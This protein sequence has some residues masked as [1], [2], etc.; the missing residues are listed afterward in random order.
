M[1]V[2][3]GVDHENHVHG[4]DGEVVCE[5]FDQTREFLRVETRG[6]DENK[7]DGDEE[8]GS[9]MADPVLGHRHQSPHED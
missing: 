3:H 2:A 8:D 5:S 6:Q 9:W 1:Q 7:G 4:R